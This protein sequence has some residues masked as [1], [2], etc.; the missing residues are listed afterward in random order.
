MLLNEIKRDGLCKVT[1]KGDKIVSFL[2]S[3]H[4]CC[5]VKNLYILI[6]D[7]ILIGIICLMV[8]DLY[9]VEYQRIRYMALYHKA[10]NFDN[11]YL[12]R[13]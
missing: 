1:K 12:F 8:Q 11:Y 10:G 6:A 13:L 9:L 2:F 7:T 5:L 3:I 4:S